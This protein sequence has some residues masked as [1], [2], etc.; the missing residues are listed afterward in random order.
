MRDKI[1]LLGLVSMAIASVVPFTGAPV[2][3]WLVTALV[4]FVVV[5][6][7]ENE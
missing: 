5:P 4:A 2:W 7:L 3:S 6:L 1:G